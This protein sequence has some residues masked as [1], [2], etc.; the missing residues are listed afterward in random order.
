MAY[1]ALAIF[2]SGIIPV[3]FRGCDGWRVNLFWAIP[4]NY[5]TCVAIGTLLLGN[6]FSAGDVARQPWIGLAAIQGILLAVNFFLL[7]RT[8]QR[9]GVAI[10]ALASR[11][12]VAVPSV[13]AFVL[14]GDAL[15]LV[16]IFG[17]SA[18]LLALFLC[19]APE[20]NADGIRSKLFQ[21]LPLLVFTTFG[22]YFTILKYLQS[23]Y[24]EA[25]AYHAYVMSAF[26]FG[27]VSSL[28]IGFG[29]RML[30]LADFHVRHLA[31]GLGLGAI[32]YLAMY[33]LLR[34]LALAGWQS[35]QLY[36]IY[37]VGV[38]AVSTVLAFVCFGELLSRQKILGLLVGVVAVALLNR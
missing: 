17:L 29:G 26:A 18:A 20:K 4:I 23:H 30:S 14:Y 8:A 16:K 7:A 35:S 37:S 19:T 31:A 27:F 28:A 24:L 6:S 3:L 5:L 34:M 11:L 13:L 38:V 25:S 33:S 22:C 21:L 32:N 10:A 9:A 36:P 1:I 12:S 15:S 2:A